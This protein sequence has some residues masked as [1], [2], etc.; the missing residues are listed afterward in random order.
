MTDALRELKL[1]GFFQ[2]CTDENNLEKLLKS[3]SITFYAGFDP[4]NISLHLGHLVPIMGMA[5]LQRMGHRAI[6]LVGGGTAMIGDP[7]GKTEARKILS[8]EEIDN[9]TEKI[10]EQ[11]E[12]F[13][14]LDNKEGILVNNAEWLRNI[15][16]IEFLRDI[17]KHFSVNRMLSFETYKEKMK[18]GLSFLEFNYILLQSY[19]FLQLFKRYDCVLQIGGDDQ[20]ANMLSGVELIRRVEKSTEV[21]CLTFPLILTS[22]GKKMG[23]TEKGAIFLSKELT[24]VFDFYQYWIN[25]TDD[26][27]IRFLKLYTFLPLEEIAKYEKLKYEELREAKEVLAFEVTK[28]VHGEEAAIEA[29]KG[30][31]AAFGKGEDFDAMPTVEISKDII[32]NGIGVLDLFVKAGLC[33]SKGEVRRLIQQNGCKVND[34]KINDEKVIIEESYVTE[35]GIILRSGKKKVCR[36]I[37]KN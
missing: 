14:K 3:K 7:T 26:D 16:Y 23:K 35:N 13:L 12:K 17:G 19:D 21:E 9:N 8:V 34:K 32:K 29:R 15:N 28:L 10:K 5:H 25:V 4:T 31:K 27:V 33:E 36:V 11:L 20:W 37:V 30:A 2:Q 22:D 18:Y 1:R 6:A 24:T